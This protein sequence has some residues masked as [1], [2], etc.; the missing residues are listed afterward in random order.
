RPG[1]SGEAVRDLQER[2]L[3]LGYD[4]SSDRLG[5]F[6]TSTAHA[7]STFQD[8]RGLRRDGVC[9]QETW[10]ALVES[11][12]TLGDRL[13]YRATPMLRGDDAR[14]LQRRLN[15][16]GFDAWR[17]DGIFGDRTAGALGEFQRNA[18]IAADG[19]CGPQTLSALV[20]LSGASLE[21]LVEGSVAS[22][23]ELESLRRGPHTLTG[24]RVFVAAEPGFERLATAVVRALLVDGA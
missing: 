4:V 1:S 16:L 19:V 8:T 9:D 22:V 7:L 11:G 21:G 10:S 3:A 13:L 23:R 5:S 18:G 2:L 17:G 6:G 15:A 24:R 14:E 12:Y 20:R